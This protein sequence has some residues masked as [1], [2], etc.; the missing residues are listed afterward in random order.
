VPGVAV[1][2]AAAAAA[3]AAAGPNMSQSSLSPYHKLIR[4]SRT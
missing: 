2:A 4:G 1:P 3:A